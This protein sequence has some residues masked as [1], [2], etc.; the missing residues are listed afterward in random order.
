MESKR[1]GEGGRERDS[2]CVYKREEG[3]ESAFI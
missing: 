2:E 1:E 3:K